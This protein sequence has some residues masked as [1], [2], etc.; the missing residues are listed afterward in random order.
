MKNH[1]KTKKMN[2]EEF[3]NIL[4]VDP[5]VSQFVRHIDKTCRPEA[6]RAFA[7]K[8]A[9]KKLR[10]DPSGFTSPLGICRYFVEITSAQS[11]AVH[12]LFT[13]FV[14]PQHVLVQWL[15]GLYLGP[16]GFRE[17][18]A[19]HYNEAARLIRI[20][21]DS[22]YKTRKKYTDWIEQALNELGIETFVRTISTVADLEAYILKTPDGARTAIFENLNDVLRE[23]EV[24]ARQCP[25]KILCKSIDRKVK[26]IQAVV[27][28]LK[29]ADA[30]QLEVPT[31]MSP[32]DDDVVVREDVVPMK[33]YERLCGLLEK[34]KI[35]YVDV[36]SDSLQAVQAYLQ[37]QEALQ[38]QCV[39]VLFSEDAHDRD[40]FEAENEIERIQ[41]NIDTA[42]RRQFEFREFLEAQQGFMSETFRDKI[43]AARTRYVTLAAQ[44]NYVDR[45]V[46]KNKLAYR[47]RS[48]LYADSDVGPFVSSTSTSSAQS[49]WWSVIDNQSV[50]HLLKMQEVRRAIAQVWE[51]KDPQKLGI[52]CLFYFYVSYDTIKSIGGG[53]LVHPWMQFV[54]YATSLKKIHTLKPNN[55]TEGL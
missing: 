14:P 49:F 21:M 24:F 42:Q 35:D 53:D 40:K 51:S 15:N 44:L 22:C 7:R 3:K 43:E 37:K 55:F 32:T 34:H 33:E 13:R 2:P 36:P 54:L 23:L 45:S 19:E 27:E 52:G 46:P 47:I 28:G 26:K 9:N 5:G 20:R 12:P 8:Q 38:Q 10:L 25:D 29:T 39:H 18:L 17:L 31:T 48:K 1:I 30:V 11:N 41:K 16:D 6:R 50:E 4:A